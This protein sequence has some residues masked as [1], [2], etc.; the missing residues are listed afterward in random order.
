MI[1]NVSRPKLERDEERKGDEP[2]LIDGDIS[3][4]LTLEDIKRM[5]SQTLEGEIIAD[6]DIRNP[7]KLYVCTATDRYARETPEACHIA[8]LPD[9]YNELS[10]TGSYGTRI[11]E[12]KLDL[13][14]ESCAENHETFRFEIRYLR[15]LLA[16]RD[17]I[18]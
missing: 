18:K 1:G 10:R 6:L 4:F 14:E 5:G 12:L 15:N 9:D 2:F 11:G 3:V 17:K 16:N 13:I 7:K 8:V